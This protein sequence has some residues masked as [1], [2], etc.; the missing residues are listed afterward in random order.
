[1]PFGTY[2]INFSKAKDV[3]LE[4]V[5]GTGDLM[6]SDMTKKLWKFIKDKGLAK[7]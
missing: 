5:F 6:P 2:R 3:T 4:K 7:S 1:M